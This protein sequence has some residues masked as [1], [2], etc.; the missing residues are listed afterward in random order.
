MARHLISL[1][2]ATFLGS[3][4]SPLQAQLTEQASAVCNPEEGFSEA[5]A[6]LDGACWELDIKCDGEIAG[7]ALLTLSGPASGDWSLAALD[8][9]FCEQSG[10][11][12][13]AEKVEVKC[14][15][16]DG[17]EVEAE[18]KAVDPEACEAEEEEPEGSP[19]SAGSA[20]GRGRS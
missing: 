14:E 18:A 10:Q 2:L 4:V 20:K 1:L 16:P 13:G 3:L 15:F 9:G 12:D 6:T 19:E 11:F 8:V 5:H 7:E 17:A